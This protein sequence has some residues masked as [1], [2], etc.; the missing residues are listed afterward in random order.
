M[1]G[2]NE[3]IAARQDWNERYGSYVANARQW[4]LTALMALG[5]AIVSITGLI[6]LASQNRLI[7]YII[8]VD[9]K[10]RAIDAYPADQIRTP[11]N[12]LIRSALANWILDWRTVT[13]DVEL[14]K[15]ALSRAYAYFDNHSQTAR[16]I[17]AWYRLNNPFERALKEL[18]HVE[19]S[20]V[21]SASEHSWR[22]NWIENSQDRQATQPP[23][24]EAFTA[25]LTIKNS[26]PPI[27]QLLLNPVGVFI[28]AIDWSQDKPL[29]SSSK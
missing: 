22:V 12:Q 27:E 23:V 9:G 17:N 2:F 1:I 19:V 25:L 28:H 4:R 15:R 13:L 7:P 10:A 20:S 29:G 5:A 18:V 3:Y 8:E 26:Q 16:K 11:G 24:K 21:L 14:Q 6:G